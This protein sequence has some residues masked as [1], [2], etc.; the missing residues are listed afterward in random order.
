MHEKK[1]NNFLE[2]GTEKELY[3]SQ[4]ISNKLEM[5]LMNKSERWVIE[6]NN[7]NYIIRLYIS[8]DCNCIT[9]YMAYYCN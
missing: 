7:C 2:F 9:Q 4:Q 5:L 8:T 6:N 1:R 3:R